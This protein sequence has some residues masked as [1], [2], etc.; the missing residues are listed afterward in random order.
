MTDLPTPPRQSQTSGVA[1]TAAPTHRERDDNYRWV[2]VELPPCHRVILGR[3]GSEYILQ[4]RRLNDEHGT[5]WKGISYPLK[6]DGLIRASVDS[7]AVS[8]GD[9]KLIELNALP[10]RASF[11]AIKPTA[12]K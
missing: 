9:P 12:K 7:E 3:L 11:D 6:L 5:Y 8:E 4:Q 10:M 1:A 2:L